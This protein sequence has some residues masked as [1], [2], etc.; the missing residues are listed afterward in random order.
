MPRKKKTTTTK[1][2]KVKPEK[3][4]PLKVKSKPP[5]PIN[6]LESLNEWLDFYKKNKK[7]PHPRIVCSACKAN[8][9][10]MKGIGIKHAMTKFDGD[11]K[12]IL[13]ESICK[14][15]KP[16]EEPKPRVV[17]FLSREDM[18]YR[19]AEIS[20]SL[21]KMKFSDPKIIDLAKNKDECKKWTYFSCHRPDIYLDHGC[22]ECVLQKHCACPIKDTQRIPDGRLRKKRK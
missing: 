11:I 14:E 13:T 6:Q 20:A 19:R 3:V 16:K 12:R 17:E 5:I 22:G 9:F 18:E 4:K 10:G 15:C 8:F 1:N 21:P 2:K 7:L